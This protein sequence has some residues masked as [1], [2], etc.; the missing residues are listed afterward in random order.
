MATGLGKTAVVSRI[1]SQWAHGNVL[2]LAHRIEL[3]DQLAESMATELGYWPF[4]E[5]GERGCDPDLLHQGGLIVCGSIQ[6]M[7]TARRRRKFRDHPFGLI[8]IDECHRATSPS[9]RSLI[10][11]Y[12]QIDPNLRVLGVTATPNRS[13]KT[14]LGIVFQ[15]VAFNMGINEGIDQGW[16]VD[17]HQKFAVLGD[18]D[19]S[20]LK[21]KLNQFGEKDFDQADLERVLSEEGTLHAMTRPVLDMAGD[22]KQAILFAASVEHARLW[23]MVMNRYRPGCAMD[24]NG[25]TDTAV[26][27][28]AVNQFKTGQ[29]QFLLNYGVF[30]EGFDAP[31]T[32]I[33]VM[34]RPTNSLLVYQ[35]MLGRGTRTIPGVVDGIPT[36]DG[37]RDAIAASVK[38]WVTVLDFV[39]NS[40]HKIITAV[41]VLGGNYDVEVKDLAAGRLASKPGNVRES[42][43]KAKAAMQLLAEEERRKAIVFDHIDYALQD[44]DTFGGVV[45]TVT[46]RKIR[47][48]AT[49][50]QIA[51]LVSLG[52][53]R[54]AALGFTKKQAGAM[55][56]KLRNERC[57]VKQGNTLRK[58]GYDPKDFNVDAASAKIDQIASNHWER[59]D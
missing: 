40:K 7:N 34:G 3:V 39:G 23:S 50:G 18:V 58:F 22:D 37:R 46:P 16:L 41:D 12:R 49:D 29:L 55:I 9:Y 14:A 32:S 33:V 27:K 2:I 53:D 48:G 51:F 35:Q 13:D 1:A 10:E 15:D 26:R 59:P 31:A 21:T 36:P 38:P 52:I 47:G 8:I 17:V 54:N 30:C 43:R 5:R 25:E 4:I 42:M 56:D 57:T 24:V 11:Y 20:A 45:T 28:Q 44:V 19:F 6:S